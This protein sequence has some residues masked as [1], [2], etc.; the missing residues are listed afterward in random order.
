MT[1]AA[2]QR[3]PVSELVH[4]RPA[5]QEDVDLVY[6][7]WLHSYWES[8]PRAL[9]GVSR[10]LYMD[11]QQGVIDELVQRA[12]VVVACDPHSPLD[13]FGWVCAEEKAGIAVV[14]YVYVKKHFRRWGLAAHL[15]TRG[16]LA[17]VQAPHGVAYTHQTRAGMPLVRRLKAVFNPYLSR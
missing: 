11:G 12:A 10:A 13:A 14:H 17:E 3:A 1:A 2:Q 6:S 15:V 8:E 9:K 4:L 16:V 7:S 5:Q